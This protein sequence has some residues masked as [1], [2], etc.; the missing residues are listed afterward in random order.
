MITTIPPTHHKGM[1]PRPSR[2]SFWHGRVAKTRTTFNTALRLQRYQSEPDCCAL[3]TLAGPCLCTLGWRKR[4]LH[5]RTF[6]GPASLP[7][8]HGRHQARFAHCGGMGGWHGRLWALFQEHTY[9]I[10]LCRHGVGPDAAP[11][12]TSKQWATDTPECGRRSV[13]QVAPRTAR[14]PQSRQ[15]SAHRKIVVRGRPQGS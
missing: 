11:S 14:L 7:F 1:L 8:R 10:E 6:S 4:Q 2:F 12:P 15:T 5:R 13:S 3:M 9:S